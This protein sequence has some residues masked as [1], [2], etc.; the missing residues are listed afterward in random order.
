[1]NFFVLCSY[2]RGDLPFVCPILLV[3][4]EDLLVIC[5]ECDSYLQVP[6]R[7]SLESWRY[8]TLTWAVTNLPVLPSDLCSIWKRRLAFRMPYLVSQIRWLVWHVLTVLCIPRSH[9][10]WIRPIG[11][12]AISEFVREQ[13]YRYSTLSFP[14]DVCSIYGRTDLPSLQPSNQRIG[15][16][17]CCMFSLCFCIRRP[18]PEGAREVGTLAV[19]LAANEPTYR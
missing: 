18:H 1:M 11:Q 19:S 6:S 10:G 16:L 14:L 5:L 8:R 15:R 2:G 9:P 4:W 13:T 12:F 7:K 3:G 17:V